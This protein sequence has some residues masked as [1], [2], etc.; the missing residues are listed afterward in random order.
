[1][2]ERDLEV[3][4]INS[5][6][7]PITKERQKKDQERLERFKRFEKINIKSKILCGDHGA[8]KDAE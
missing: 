2:N 4:D 8:R 7:M 3:D 1:M 5:P 6:D